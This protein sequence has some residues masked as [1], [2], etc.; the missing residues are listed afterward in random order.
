[1]HRAFKVNQKLFGHTFTQFRPDLPM[2]AFLETRFFRLENLNFAKNLITFFATCQGPAHCHFVVFG[3][4]KNIRANFCFS[5]P[6]LFLS[7]T[8]MPRHMRLWQVGSIPSISLRWFSLKKIMLCLLAFTH[9]PDL[10]LA[11]NYRRNIE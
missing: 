9:R 5:L 7:P 10:H 8:V 11:F 1:M 4:V 3:Q 2:M 6:K